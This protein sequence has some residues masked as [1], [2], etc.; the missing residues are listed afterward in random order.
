MESRGRLK[1]D[2]NVFILSLRQINNRRVYSNRTNQPERKKTKQ[3]RHLHILD[4]SRKQINPSLGE[5]GA[6]RVVYMLALSI[7]RYV[8]MKFKCQKN[9]CLCNPKISIV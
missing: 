2:V 3:T 6:S 4:D 7:L 9:S 8:L 5:N 1:I